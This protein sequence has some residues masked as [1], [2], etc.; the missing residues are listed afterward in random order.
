[1]DGTLMKYLNANFPEFGEITEK[2]RKENS[3]KIFI[4][5]VRISSGMYR[6]NSEDI[7]RRKKVLQ[8]R[9]P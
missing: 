6:T 2:T 4:G 9:L 3:K 5:G 7:A 8:T 1:M